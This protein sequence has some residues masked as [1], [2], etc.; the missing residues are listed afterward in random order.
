MSNRP[1]L[2]ENI[3]ILLANPNRDS[4][5]VGT[6][7]QLSQDNN[8]Q[9][10]MFFKN[11]YR[12]CPFYLGYPSEFDGDHCALFNKRDVTIIINF[13]NIADGNACFGKVKI[14]NFRNLF[15]TAT[16]LRV[17]EIAF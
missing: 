16:G 6:K 14:I 11:Y 1:E 5:S 10:N 3:P 9:K 15:D 8:K 12:I 2:D 7:E 17:L 13:E 4:I